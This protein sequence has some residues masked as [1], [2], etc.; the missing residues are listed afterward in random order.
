MVRGEPEGPRIRQRFYSIL[1]AMLLAFPT[2][3]SKSYGGLRAGGSYTWMYTTLEQMAGGAEGVVYINVYG[4][5][6]YSFR[7]CAN[8]PFM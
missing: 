1:E 5:T 2:S 3:V 7:T 8:R 4:P 6:S